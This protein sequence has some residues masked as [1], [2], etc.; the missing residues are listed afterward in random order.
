M[1]SSS[2][3]KDFLSEVLPASFPSI[4]ELILS[5]LAHQD[6]DS[7][8]RVSKSLEA[9]LALP[10]KALKKR[11][12]DEEANFLWMNDQASVEREFLRKASYK[13]GDQVV[14]S[15]VDPSDGSS[16]SLLLEGRLVHILK[17]GTRVFVSRANHACP[18]NTEMNLEG[19]YVV[20]KYP[21]K[22]DIVWPIHFGLG[23]PDFDREFG[24]PRMEFIPKDPYSK[25]E[26]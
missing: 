25:T 11:L 17:N 16:F 13:Q 14:C 18:L 15:A 23:R 2:S 6:L 8:S 10:G 3:N 1:E 5:H 9:F 26:A 22:D 19:D 20:L 24:C 21:C 12:T 7:C 4:L